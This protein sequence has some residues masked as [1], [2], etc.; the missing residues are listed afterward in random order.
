M[1]SHHY[2]Q[3]IVFMMK[4][5]N[6]GTAFGHGLPT[7]QIDNSNYISRGAWLSRG[8]LNFYKNFSGKILI[9]FFALTGGGFMSVNG[10]TGDLHEAFVGGVLPDGP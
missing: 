9:L 7:A 8:N 4:K 1:L 6:D 3:K 2:K 10:L 5:F